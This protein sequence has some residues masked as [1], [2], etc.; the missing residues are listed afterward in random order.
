MQ[1][2]VRLDERF[3]REIVG[4]RDVVAREPA[5][6]APK[7]RLVPPHEQLERASI[8]IG[9]D[10]CDEQGI[11]VCHGLGVAACFLICR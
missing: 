9:N 4:A 6:E 3:L 2:P 1:A 7:R 8:I 10:A 5:Q 11:A